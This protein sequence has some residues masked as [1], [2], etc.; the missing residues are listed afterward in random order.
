MFVL[1]SVVFHNTYQYF[2]LHFGIFTSR[3]ISMGDAEDPSPARI[4]EIQKTVSK[5]GVTC[6]FT[7][8]QYNPGIVRNVFKGKDQ[9]TI[10]IMDSIDADIQPVYFNPV[11]LIQRYKWLEPNLPGCL[12]YRQ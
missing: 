10:G 2:E 8:P 12:V 6:V 5:L 7:E 3:S 1:T 11:Y 4:Q 9:I